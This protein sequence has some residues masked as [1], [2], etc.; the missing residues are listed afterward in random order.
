MTKP[1][2]MTLGE[3]IDHYIASVSNILSPTTILEYES[4]RR[5]R[6][7]T[8]MGIKLADLTNDIMQN[9]VNKDAERVPP[10]TIRNGFSLVT[11][12]LKKYQKGF[13]VDVALPAKVK[14]DIK[15]PSDENIKLAL[16]RTEGN[17]MYTVILLAAFLGLRRSEICGLTWEDV[18]FE[19]S[20]IR[21]NKTMLKSK[22][23]EKGTKFVTKQKTKT[24]LSTRRVEAPLILMNHI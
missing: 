8:M 13:E 3:A 10:K 20:M 24:Y 16:K 1:E 21:I 7:Q 11:K 18:D 4:E 12:V 15:L 2:N 14:T 23:S 17:D 19:N 6:F 22:R 9:A 5:S